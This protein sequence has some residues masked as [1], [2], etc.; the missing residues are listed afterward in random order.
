MMSMLLEPPTR[1]GSRASRDDA[2]APRRSPYA[3]RQRYYDPTVGRF[4]TQDP[5]EF[6]AGDPNLYRYVGNSPLNATDPSG[7]SAN[8]L[9]NL[10]GSLGS[11]FN[12]VVP[13]FGS[14]VSAITSSM[15]HIASGGPMALADGTPIQLA[16]GPA[17]WDFDPLNLSGGTVMAPGASLAPVSAPKKEM[18]LWLRASNDATQFWLNEGLGMPAY[19]INSKLARLQAGPILA[20]E[21]VNGRVE[22]NAT[23]GTR[24]IAASMGFG[25]NRAL[26]APLH[27]L[28]AA[29]SL[30]D[31]SEYDQHWLYTLSTLVTNGE[32]AVGERR[33]AEALAA[34]GPQ[35]TAAPTR[36]AAPDRA[37]AV[38]RLLLANEQEP[39]C[40]SGPA[41]VPRSCSTT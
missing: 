18:P 2:A 1:R 6:E 10:G 39:R 15:S 20:D 8:P 14:V 23:F 21:P 32:R 41:S 3:H 37:A 34:T 9:A 35:L 38:E 29:R 25:E 30:A 24:D 31:L 26:Y 12:S 4:L 5:E 36:P 16:S 40:R 17:M 22:I 33:A 7:L 19:A 11:G 13:G 28:D 27:S